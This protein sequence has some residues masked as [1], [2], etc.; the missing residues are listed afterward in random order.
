MYDVN[1]RLVYGLRTIGKGLSAGKPLS[2]V[3]NLPQPPTRFLPNTDSIGS[4]VEDVCFDSMKDAVNEAVIYNNSK[5]DIAVALDGTWQKRGHS[6]LNGMITATSFDTGKVIDVSLLSKYCS[7]DNKE[8]HLA[9]C[10]TNYNGS[11]GGVEVQ[12]AAETFSRSVNE[13]NVRYVQYSGDGDSK[14]FIAVQDL[15]SYGPG[16]QIKKLEC[17][18]HIQKRMGTRLRKLKSENKPI[19]L[20]DGKG[21]GGKNRLTKAVIDQPTMVQH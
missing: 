3:L 2:G 14:G 19:N 13:Y 9:S 17:I 16:C 11:S 7:C 15:Q 5:R 18:G 20:S 10:S 1:L 4:A 6:S 21:L 12:D 8:N